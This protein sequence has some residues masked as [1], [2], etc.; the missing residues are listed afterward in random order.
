MEVFNSQLIVEYG[1]CFISW[2]GLIGGMIGGEPIQS[3]VLDEAPNTPD[4][5]EGVQCRMEV[6]FLPRVAQII[7]EDVDMHMLCSPS[8]WYVYILC[9]SKEMRIAR[10]ILAE[11]WMWMV[12]DENKNAPDDADGPSWSPSWQFGT[13]G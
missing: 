2:G 7:P 5:D 3:S 4:V 11:M 1:A 6:R 12:Y 8:E 13:Q 9:N 10:I